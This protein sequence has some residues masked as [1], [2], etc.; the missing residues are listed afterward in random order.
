MNVP[1]NIDFGVDANISEIIK[2]RAENYGYDE[3]FYV[4]DS[5]IKMFYID[6]DNKKGIK[7]NF[8]KC[9]CH[10]CPYAKK[11]YKN[12]VIIQKKHLYRCNCIK[13][14]KEYYDYYSNTELWDGYI[15]LEIN[16]KICKKIYKNPDHKIIKEEII[17][18]EKMISNEK[19]ILNEDNLFYQ[20]G[21]EH[22]E[23]T[24]SAP[25]EI[26]FINNKNIKYYLKKMF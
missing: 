14:L 18:N 20:R 15:I 2:S 13:G 9:P 25:P 26:Y 23:V 24:E 12:I 11:N 7:Y 10:K 22:E 1:I 16:C 4:G 6:K 19:I 8:D 21:F 5:S 3:F 17:L